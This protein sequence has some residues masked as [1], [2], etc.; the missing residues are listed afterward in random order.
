MSIAV[1]ADLAAAIERP[2]RTPLVRV[3]V[4]WDGD[5]FG[6]TGSIDDLSGKQGDVTIDR[7][8]VTDLPAQVRLVEG[9]AA[10]TSTV[11]LAEGDPTDETMHAARY[12]SRGADS[13]LGSK[14]RVNRPCTVDIGF[15]TDS[16][17]QYVR[18]L[19]GRT[20]NMHTGSRGR[21]ATLAALDN[22]ALLRNPVTLVPTNGNDAGADG[23]WIVTQA[24]A[25][26]G[27][28]AGPAP[29]AVGSLVWC[30]FY[31]SL[32]PVSEP[33]FSG[34]SAGFFNDSGT[35]RP[36][37]IA[38]P[39][40]LAAAPHIT[41]ATDYAELFVDV[42]RAST[43]AWSGTSGRFELWVQGVAN[44][45]V[46][47]NPTSSG[48][49]YFFYSS[50]SGA[51]QANIRMGVGHD[52]RM[53]LKVTDSPDA[54]LLH[55]Y[56]GT[57]V[58]PPDG[59]WHAV[60]V[61]FDFNAQTVTFKVDGS[62]ETLTTAVLPSEIPGPIDLAQVV[63]WAPMSDVHLHDVAAS[64]PWL[65]DTVVIGAILDPSALQLVAS[66][67]AVPR[68]A[69][70]LVG[71]VAGAEQAVG[72]FDENGLFRYRTRARLVD[73]AGQTIQ[74][75]LTTAD[76]SL[77]DVE[78][79]DGIDQVRNIVQVS[80]TPA[81]LN[82]AD[83]FT[84]L[85][86]YTSTTLTAVPARS[87]VQIQVSF[88]NPVILLQQTIFLQSVA[89]FGLF[90]A[91]DAYVVV[92]TNADGS[93]DLA[94]VY[95]YSDQFV[96]SVVSWTPT[97]AV[98]EYASTAPIPL[99]VTAVGIKGSSVAVGTAVVVEA[100]DQASIDQYGP[101]LLQLT[102][103]QWVQTGDV[104]QSLANALL[105]DI[106]DPHP[107]VQGLKIVGDPRRQLGD[108]VVLADPDGTRLAGE[109][110]L[111]QIQDAVTNAGGYEQTIAARQATTVMRWG[112]GHW[113]IETWG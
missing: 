99:Y 112:V 30:P 50:F 19:T 32:I 86:V 57:A 54:V 47:P 113:G 22:R 89:V 24:L 84:F 7:T 62:Y 2:E 1:S 107:E 51:I 4:D 25:A 80:Y 13:P 73:T 20:R 11:T 37:F 97:G 83:G 58:V 66:Y 88:D 10:A 102:L 35:E 23:T 18:R 98:I 12:F 31:G 75:I 46:P 39:F 64:E 101:Q 85:F 41:T 94:A 91:V 6:P 90:P 100:R 9:T 33:H 103:P 43:I 105:G 95:S 92:T 110:W 78:V 108:R 93:D 15:V 26:N 104:A 8:L 27:I 16:G 82:Q 40:A 76:V 81:V 96:A 68:E 52:G 87:V 17:P 48:R 65:S 61:H 21:T 74:R 49:H 67:E 79:D 111:T 38:G 45:T 53:F 70:E 72:I 36:A 5:G 34:L 109:Y 3:M 60:G 69:W 29:R 55:L 71:E 59:G 56:Q 44:P 42:A 14:E 106:K 77:L 28:Y 63:G